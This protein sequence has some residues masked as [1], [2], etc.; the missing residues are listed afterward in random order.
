MRSLRERVI[1]TLWF[2]LLGLAIVAPLFAFFSGATPGESFVLLLVLAVVVTFWSGFYNSAFDRA[3]MR[4]TGRV[5]SDRPQRWRALHAVGLEASAM[6]MTWPL[7][8]ALT[9]LGWHA[10]L[11]AELGL[12]VAYVVY[13]YAFH[14]VFDRLRPVMPDGGVADRPSPCS[15]TF[16]ESSS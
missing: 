1:Q 12:T 3:E 8:V 9:P 13:G 2:E 15:P 4:L 16:N 6:V 5:A 11:V 14:L 10:A 7:V